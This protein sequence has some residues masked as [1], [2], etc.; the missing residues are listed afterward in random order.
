[1][2]LKSIKLN[3]FRSYF[4]FHEIDVS[5][6]SSGRKE[7][8][9][10]LFGGLNGAGKTSILTAVKLALYGKYSLGTAVAQKKYEEYLQ[11]C[12]HIQK[13]SDLSQASSSVGLCF[14]FDKEGTLVEYE[15]CRSW[16]KSKN[17]CIENLSIFENNVELKSLKDKDAENY[18]NQLV[19]LG[20]SDLFFFDGEKI[21]ELAEDESGIALGAAIKKLLG[22]DL[23][24]RLRADLRVFLLS[25]TLGGHEGVERQKLIDDE[26][27]FSDLKQRIIGEKLEL[28]GLMQKYDAFTKERETL[29]LQLSEIG[30]DYAKSRQEQQLLA[31]KLN[32]KVGLANREL[33]ENLT[34][35]FPLTLAQELLQELSSGVEEVVDREKKIAKNRVLQD[36]SDRLLSKISLKDKDLKLA[37]KTLSESLEK[38][39]VGPK[40][41]P[42]TNQSEMNYIDGLVKVD[43]PNALTKI[44]ELSENIEVLQQDLEVAA[45]KVERAPDE[46][47]LEL[48]LSKIYK[49]SEKAHEVK[50]EIKV[51]AAEISVLFNR[52]IELSRTLTRGHETLNKKI[53]LSVPLEHAVKARE[54]MLEFSELRVASKVIE[55]QEAFLKSFDLLMRKKGSIASAKIDP[56]TFSVEL[57]S[58]SGEQLNKN[59][60]SA[61]E[62]QIYAIAMLDS[63]AKTSGNHLPIIID[64]PLGRLDSKH[65]AKLV[66][67]YF[68][69]ASHQVLLLSTDTEIDEGHYKKLAKFCAKKL[70]IIFDEKKG[71]SSVVDGY[72]F[73]SKSGSK[74]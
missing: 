37:K 11:E 74:A 60:L 68:P 49:V 50:A 39:F 12:M 29:E 10:I 5:P 14:S 70:E 24:D 23:V 73:A 40:F 59:K 45:L 51:R 1:M 72:F 20:V 3:N 58:F 4:G 2:I 69:S 26:K 18:L 9:V 27:A 52:T 13:Q 46:R 44:G 36:F 42:E 25:N 67:D 17:G 16:E 47:S 15:I 35:L 8:P 55:L 54:L 53:G 7:K 63:L 56:V 28:E 6:T 38:I 33:R 65:R 30:G 57:F 22:I 64:T 61:G 48:H 71:R 32:D 34:N 66:N 62:K 21:A 19:P 43:V 31:E 41:Y